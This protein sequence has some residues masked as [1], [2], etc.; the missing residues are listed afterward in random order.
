MIHMGVIPD[1]NQ[2]H[3]RS[4]SIDAFKG[5]APIKFPKRKAFLT[6]E[7]SLALTVG[8]YTPSANSRPASS[9][10]ATDSFEQDSE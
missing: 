5:L 1:Q 9:N 3:A 10:V 4:V 7:P 8:R 2:S 6:A